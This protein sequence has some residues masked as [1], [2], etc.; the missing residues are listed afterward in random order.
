VL[1]KLE[2]LAAMAEE[3]GLSW[4]EESG[5]SWAEGLVPT[6]VRRHMQLLFGLVAAL[7]VEQGLS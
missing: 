4:A 3:S 7:E 2:E 6:S 5:L 1:G